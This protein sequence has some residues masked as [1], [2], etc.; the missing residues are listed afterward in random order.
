MADLYDDNVKQQMVRLHEKLSPEVVK[1]IEDEVIRLGP[2]ALQLC[3]TFPEPL[4][5]ARTRHWLK[6]IALKMDREAVLPVLFEAL[7]HPDWRLFQIAR[8]ALT[9]MGTEVRDELVD[10][11]EHCP[12]ATGRVQAL[13]CIHRLADPYSPLEVGDK[14]LIPAIEKATKDESE[15]VRAMAVQVLSR[16]E[17]HES[18]K[19]LVDALDD[20]SELV[21]RKAVD[22]CGRLR[23]ADAATPLLRFLD[24]ED[25]QARADAIRALDRIGDVSTA[26]AVRKIMKDADPYVR[27]S[28]ATA[29]E[30]LWENANVQALREAT[31]DE[32]PVVAVAALE[33]LARKSDDKAKDL[34]TEMSKSTKPF[35]SKAAKH[36]L[37]AE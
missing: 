3:L 35:M 17:A 20:P 23:L 32:E 25:P 16:S 13:W 34:L 18:S 8:D 11:L 24:H 10:F 15:H 14:T 36:Y 1:A 30:N 9:L 31:K 12:V 28:A 29:L 19:A 27:W 26:A 6:E 7:A 4:I 22:A 5:Y 37:S 21:R 2:E 33:I